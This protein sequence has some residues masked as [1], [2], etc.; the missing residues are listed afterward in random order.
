[1]SDTEGDGKGAEGGVNVKGAE[2]GVNIKDLIRQLQSLSAEEKKLIANAISPPALDVNPKVSSGDSTDVKPKVT[3]GDSTDVKPKVT[4]AT[5]VEGT[6]SRPS[7][8]SLPQSLIY[9]P[10][11]GMFSGDDGKG[12]ISFEQFKYEV[13]SLQH[14]GLAEATIQQCI[15]RSVRGTAAEIIHNLGEVDI[16]SILDKLDQI[17]GN[18]LP[19]ENILETFYSAKQLK[20][21]SVAEWACRLERIMA[22]IRKKERLSR[23]DGDARLRS[24]FFAGLHK[25]PVKNAVRHRYDQGASYK[26]LLVAAR[27]AELEEPEVTQV[28]AIALPDAKKFD[29]IMA[30]IEKMNKRLERLENK[31]TQ[32]K[33]E[34]PKNPPATQWNQRSSV[35]WNSR[36]HQPSRDRSQSYQVPF[37]GNCY[38]C[39]G[40][41]HR[42]HECPLNYYNPV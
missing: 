19:S 1:M 37:S 17:F 16:R 28:Q 36:E 22:Q 34:A 33:T 26:D 39:G 3:S 8:Q 12:E 4:S 10:R 20:G 18:V 2:G 38:N 6:P 14:E 23:G 32:E 24:K 25:P 7:P 42:R 41:G 9:S 40:V 27:V 30:A 5:F 31:G 29:D 15:R 21:E 35:P 11:I 13:E